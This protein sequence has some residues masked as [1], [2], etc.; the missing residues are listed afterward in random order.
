MELPRLI[1]A[2]T[3]PLAKIPFGAMVIGA[4]RYLEISQTGDTASVRSKLLEH[5][6]EVT[7]KRS[8]TEW[9]IVGVKDEQLATNIARG[10]G[11]EIIAVAKAGPKGQRNGSGLPNIGDLLRQAE[12]IFKT[13]Q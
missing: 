7:M 2:K 11:Q 1:R 8:G 5:S 9:R 13:A 10:I 12:E 6:F 3:A 4:D